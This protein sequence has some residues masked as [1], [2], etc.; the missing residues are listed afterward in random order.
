MQ[1][2]E[3]KQRISGN[4][5]ER[6][7]EQ[8]YVFQNGLYF[9]AVVEDAP[10]FFLFYKIDIDE[11][12]VIRAGECRNGNRFPD[13]SGAFD[14]QRLVVGSVLPFCE[15]AIYLSSKEFIHDIHIFDAVNILIFHGIGAKYR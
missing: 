14:D 15:Y 1:F 12:F 3:K 10:V 5:R 8:R 13:L 7:I 11:T 2:V 6:G 4:E 9:I